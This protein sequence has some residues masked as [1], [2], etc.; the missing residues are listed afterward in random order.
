MNDALSSVDELQRL[1]AELQQENA[2]CLWECQ[3]LAFALQESERKFK[4][5]V[6]NLPER[7][8]HK[9]RESVYV[10]CNRN[11]AVEW[12]LEP[13]QMVGKTDYDFF[14]PEIAAKYRADDSRIMASGGTE[15]IEESYCTST[16]EERLIC[17][18]KA[19]L[20][21]EHGHVTGIL[22]IFSDI[23][24]RKRA[25]DAL[26]RSEARYRALAEATTD[27]IYIVDREGRL[28]YANR[29]A[30]QIINMASDEIAGKRQTDLF[31][32]E[33]AQAHMEKIRRIFASNDASEEDELFTFGTEQVWLRVHLFP[34]RD[35]AGEVTS[36][37]GV[38]H[39]ITGRKRAEEALQKAR[40]ELERRVEERTAELGQANRQL[41][42]EVEERERIEAELRQSEERY[43]LAA[44]GAGAGI[45]DW[46]L[47]TGKVYYSPRWKMIFGYEEHEIGESVD[48]WASRLHPDE[49]E[50]IIKL[51]DDFLAST[52]LSGT[53]QYRLRH[54]DGSYRW[55]IAHG[56]VV[57]DADGKACRFVGS[58]SDITDRKQAEEALRQSEA[59]Y[60]ALIESCPDPVV[61]VDLLGRFVFASQRAAEQHGILN[62]DELV[63][64]QV[65]DF[66][67]ESDRDRLKESFTRLLEDRVHRNVK[68]KLLRTDGTKFDAEFSSAV[69][70]DAAGTPEALMAVYRDITDRKQAEEKLRANDAELSAAAEIQ[71]HLLP[72]EPPRLPGFDIA[73]RCYP[74]EAAAGDDFDYL[75][76]HDGSLL[77]VLGDVSGHGLGPA[78]VAADFCARLRTLSESISDLPE[79]AT[80]L[81]AGLYWET[82]GEIFVT[83]ILGSLNPTARSLTCLSA[84]HPEAIVLNSAGEVR[85]RNSFGGLP[86]AILP[87]A[88]FVADESVE[89]AD[90]DLVLFYTDGLV[91]VQRPGEPLFGIDRA[92]QVVRENQQR[93]AVE[94]VDALYRSACQYA[95]A[96]K[97]N[98]DITLVV[99]KVLEAASNLAPQ[100][101]HLDDP[102]AIPCVS[103]KSSEIRDTIGSDFFRA[104][105]RG[106]ITITRIVDTGDFDTDKY[107]QLQHDFVDFVERRRPRELLV[108]LSD[109]EY[110]ST[111]LIN[112]FLTAQNRMKSWA[113]AMKLFGLGEFVRE[114][115]Q[116]LNLIGTVFAVCADETTAMNPFA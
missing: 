28:L 74:A 78:L 11:Y 114:T 34:L 3:C 4:A 8:F 65:A 93:S 32:P 101:E 5:L 84:G 39:N 7:V 112:T 14:R 20:R 88:R 83:A 58:H 45:W 81:N 55:I 52:S 59:R 18:V 17:T 33:T 31:S 43:Q 102:E 6:Y 73:G 62:P 66:F 113:G 21:D 47:R 86:F 10:S 23:T 95:G 46:N 19:P 51:Q 36:V 27:I 12:G 54:K 9:D 116:H 77:I 49:R 96:E 76:L 72:Q 107:V 92:L 37:M 40:D 89:L 111:A 25:E 48:D 85:T 68:Y 16:G 94:I 71:A 30:L 60:R 100:Q 106:E 103:R 50:S 13:E 67:V 99:V 15:E 56:L 69:I 57:R 29:A 104:D 35:E 42:R 61:M 38:C 24:E 82:A 109:I 80:R 97:P 79:I 1:V 53:A 26:R 63:G 22:G 115:L 98:D 44:R 110:C 87:E 41:Q 91:E 90:G 75:W 108:D 64:T 2:K 70:A 105:Q